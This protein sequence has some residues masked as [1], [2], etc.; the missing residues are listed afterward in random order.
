MSILLSAHKISKSFSSR[1][2]FAELTFSVESSDRIGLIGPNG[3]GKS[4]LLRILS[5][6]IS[7]DTG[8][9][10]FTSGIKIGFLEQTPQFDDNSSI[11]ETLIKD[12]DPEDWETQGH[13]HEYISRFGLDQ[14]ESDAN[15][16]SLSGGWQK[17]VALARE[18]IKKPDLLLLDEPTNHLDIEGIM[19]LEDYLSRARF[20]TIT[21]THDRLFLQRVSNSIIELNTRHQG[22][23][24][25]VKGDYAKYLEI[26]EHL[27]NSQERR[28][29]ILKNTLRRET[30]WLRQGAKARTTKQHARIERA[31]DL[32]E[33]VESLTVRNKDRSANFEFKS[34]DRIPKRLIEAEKISKSYGEKTIF[35]DFSIKI[36]PRSRIGLLG[37][38][39]AGKSTLIRVLMGQESPDSG[40]LFRSD[41]LELTYFDQKRETLDP[42]L[43]VKETLC[44]KGSTVDFCGR[45]IHVNSYLDRFLFDTHQAGME[46]GRLSGGE[47]SRLLIAQLML[48][49][50]NILILDEPTNDLDMA[51]LTVLEECIREFEGAVI[52]VSHDRYF[53]DQVT[54]QL[55]AFPD[56]Q[57]EKK[58]LL[59]FSDFLQWETWKRNQSAPK[60]N[61]KG[62]KPTSKKSES[63]SGKQNA[64][65]NMRLS[66]KD[67]RELD[68]MESSIQA[69]EAQLEEFTAKSADP[70]I[71]SN[72]LALTELTSEMSKIQKTIE[73]LYRRWEELESKKK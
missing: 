42:N 25:K 66:F 22:G 47:Q 52:L 23:L 64:V 21:V 39:G 51:T 5:K 59:V 48:K 46:V 13:A 43:T 62:A 36:G 68:G 16:T 4:T 63:T 33:S 1:P 65:S 18:L 32:K 30:E 70:K 11:I 28:E 20:A 50:A 2:L 19:W 49:R 17:R 7:P 31:G 38:N 34:L 26:R 60:K 57:T 53:L 45:E 61:T 44:P 67:Q 8:E 12:V 15:V 54:D 10:S 27:I 3:M 40:E 71:I 24:L 69:A 41:Q 35:S 6:Q 56:P 55:I 58:E 72:P 29:V 73:A 9:L 14:F 37:E